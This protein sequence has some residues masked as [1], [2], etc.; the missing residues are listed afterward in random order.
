MQTSYM[1]PGPG[2]VAAR[3]R[4]QGPAQ[5]PCKMS[6]FLKYMYRHVYICILNICTRCIEQMGCGGKPLSYLGAFVVLWWSFG[7]VFAGFP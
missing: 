6:A 4:P 3:P 1:G 2:P 7:L 5:G